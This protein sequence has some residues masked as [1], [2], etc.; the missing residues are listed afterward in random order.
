MSDGGVTGCL[1]AIKAARR[2][3]EMREPPPEC[4]LAYDLHRAE[5]FVC[6]RVGGRSQCGEC[7]GDL[8]ET[9]GSGGGSGHLGHDPQYDLA[10]PSS[11]KSINRRNNSK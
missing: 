10:A 7:A 5:G 3:R 2:W 6:R 9:Q 8:L 11:E 1:A 4:H